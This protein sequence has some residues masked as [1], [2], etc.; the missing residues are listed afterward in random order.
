MR[1]LDF[2]VIVAIVLAAL[3]G[4]YQF[5]RLEAAVLAADPGAV[6]RERDRATQAIRQ[7]LAVLP[8]VPV[9]TILAY[10]GQVTGEHRERL[11][12]SGYLPCDGTTLQ[13]TPDLEPLFAAIEMFWGGDSGRKEFRVPNLQGRFVRGAN[14]DQKNVKFEED[15]SFRET[16]GDPDAAARLSSADGGAN[17]N[18]VGTLQRFGT[19]LPKNPMKTNVD[20]AHGHFLPMKR[21]GGDECGFTTE[22]QAGS[23]AFCNREGEPANVTPARSEHSHTLGAGGDR[24]T[25][26]LNVAVNWIIKVHDGRNTSAAPPRDLSS[27]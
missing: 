5:A 19:A 1:K 13:R 18:H 23:G 25:R 14:Q 4:T 15:E 27:H 10:G 16:W 17:G 6:V 21:D 26:P 7:E 3:G 2:A 9:G 12:R 24:E 22:P 20:G 11:W 8:S